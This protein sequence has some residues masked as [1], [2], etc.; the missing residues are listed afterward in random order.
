MISRKGSCRGQ[1]ARNASYAVVECQDVLEGGT[2]SAVGL[3][4]Q[5]ELY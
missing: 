2:L 5:E 3:N 4:S 1:I